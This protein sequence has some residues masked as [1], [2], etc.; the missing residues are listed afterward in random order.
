M[1]TCVS[2]LKDVMRSFRDLCDAYLVKPIDL[3]RLLEHIKAYDLVKG[4]HRRLFNTA[5]ASE[6]SLALAHFAFSPR[7]AEVPGVSTS[8]TT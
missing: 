8:I 6:S 7:V 4:I 3:A 5:R 1:T 2:D